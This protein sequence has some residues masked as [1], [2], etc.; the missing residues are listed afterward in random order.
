MTSFTPTRR[1]TL[2]SIGGAFLTRSSA[3]SIPPSGH[4]SA[5][6]T[7]SV[8][9]HIPTE[10]HAAIVQGR[11]RDDLTRYFQA[12]VVAANGGEVRGA[13]PGGVVIVPPGTY[14]VTRVGIRNTVLVGEHRLGSRIVAASTA[15]S[16]IFLL[17]A[18]LDRDGTTRNSEG[19]GYASHLVIDAG[20][21]GA[22]GLRTYGGGCTAQELTIIGAATGLAAGLPL[23]ATFSNIHTID[24]D[25]G[26][27]TFAL[28]RG[29][30]GTSTTFLNCWANRS[31]RHG[32][33]VTQLMYSS[34]INCAAQDSGDTNFLIEG[35]A[36][37][38]PA[39]YS[40]QL[41]GCGTEGR[42]KPFRLR[43]CRDLTLVGARVVSPSADTDH[44]VFD[45]SAG[46]VRDFSTV[47]PPAAPALSLR[48]VNHGAPP[49]G[50]LID[51]SIMTIDPRSL[52]YFT[53]VGGSLND[54]PGIHGPLIGITDI[55]GTASARIEPAGK[56]PALTWRSSQA[57]LAA[58]PLAGGT[59][60][61]AAQSDL[62]GAIGAGE[63][64]ISLSPDRSA[65]R[66]TFKD[67]GGKTRIVELPGRTLG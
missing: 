29:D 38:N 9:D 24:C 37:G 63:V 45:D 11:C 54:R 13:G 3:S 17:D 27:H 30:S 61:S 66:L 48:L 53:R 18:L 39:A 49:G 57:R 46:S 44:I 22:S 56:D 2:A 12:A 41:I 65:L 23:W 5:A 42:G 8:L 64:G 47:E 40:L 28:E 4:A 34:L 50:V 52:P 14:P 60:L 51:G 35:D 26:F 25:V 33:H 62:S 58:F 32:F 55:A 59:I 19:G 36:N 7:V 15:K 67:G 10:L 1:A 21:S 20:G 43:R 16:N 6:R 31:R